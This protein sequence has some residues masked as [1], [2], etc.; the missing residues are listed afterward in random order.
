MAS[1]APSPLGPPPAPF[2][3]R[4][5][6][7]ELSARFAEES[8]A[9]DPD[10]PIASESW[11][12]VGAM[13]DHLG[14]IQRWAAQIVASGEAA[15]REEFLRPAGR[16]RAEWMAES[17]AALMHALDNAEPDAACWAFADPRTASFWFRRQA[18]EARKH[19]W[20]I[21][22]ASTATP[23]LPDAGGAAMAA[24]ILDEL[25]GVFLARSRRKGTLPPLPAALHLRATDADVAWTIGADWTTHR[26]SGADTV[27]RGNSG[28]DAAAGPDDLILSAALGDLVLFGWDRAR[29]EDLPGRFAVDGDPAAIAAFRD[30]P[31]HP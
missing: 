18:H 26:G 14:Q 28:A 6:V 13:I 15:P 3:H 31:V 7:R 21:R 23:P 17:S 2:A 20:D 24:D 10:A 22:T 29:P 12:T 25:F 4:D 11:P 27:D 9:L 8:A 19:L 5:A 1:M 30:A 16:E